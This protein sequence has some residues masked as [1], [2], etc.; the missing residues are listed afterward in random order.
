MP[1]LILVVLGVYI[2]AVGV[3]GNGSA[4]LT[5]LQKD[6]PGFI[7]WILAIIII[8]MLAIDQNTEKLGKPLLGL[9]FLGILI[10]DWPQIKTNATTAYKDMTS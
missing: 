8:G 6:L 7:P 4:L 1:V 2:L 5:E 10:K 3:M 9:I